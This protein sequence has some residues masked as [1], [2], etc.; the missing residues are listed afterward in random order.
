MTFDEAIEKARKIR[1]MYDVLE[2]RKYGKK[3]DRRDLI[4]GFV[5][6]VGGLVKTSMMLDGTREANPDSKHLFSEELSDCLW[7]IIIL[8][9]KYEIDLKES[10]LENMQLLEQRLEEEKTE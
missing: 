6:D 10:F 5:N 8:A 2:E 7:S 3:W 1:K 4:L 9:D